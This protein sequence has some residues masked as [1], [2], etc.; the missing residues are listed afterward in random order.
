MA[1]VCPASVGFDR[2]RDTGHFDEALCFASEHFVLGS[3][4]DARCAPLAARASVRHRDHDGALP[5][6]FREGEMISIGLT[7]QEFWGSV[8]VLCTVGLFYFGRSILDAERAAESA[9]PFRWGDGQRKVVSEPV[10]MSH[11]ILAAFTALVVLF[12]LKILM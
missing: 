12:V 4:I 3:S 6:L 7:Q 1:H 5:L 10:W 2:R 8:I 9:K 11:P